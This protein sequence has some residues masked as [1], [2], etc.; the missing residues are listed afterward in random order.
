MIPPMMKVRGI[1]SD[2]GLLF[3]TQMY[4]LSQGSEIGNRSGPSFSSTLNSCML[5]ETNL[6][7]V[8]WLHHFSHRLYTVFVTYSR[9]IVAI[10]CLFFV[11]HLFFV[12]SVVWRF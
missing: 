8:G 11:R 10:P 12:W 6:C 5:G 4:G 3:G 9:N 2:L 1:S 7:C